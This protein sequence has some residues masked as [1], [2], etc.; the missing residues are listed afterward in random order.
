MSGCLDN[1]RCY[2]PEWTCCEFL[3]DV[4][5]SEHRNRFASIFSG[6]FFFVGWW[7]IIDAAVYPGWSLPGRFHAVGVVSTLAFFLINAISTGQ[8]SGDN[9]TDG[10]IGQRGARVWMFI[11]FLMAFAGLIA[12]AWIL[13]GVYVVPP[14]I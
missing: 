4:E 1:V 12:A 14:Q 7:I 3:R 10:F 9:Y 11:G 6:I 2:C 13:F 5:W 8:L